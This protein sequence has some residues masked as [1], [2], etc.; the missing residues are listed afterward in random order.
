[1]TTG[2]ESVGGKTNPNIQEV[3]M[4]IKIGNSYNVLNTVPGT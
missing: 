4:R 3:I 1:M 2:W